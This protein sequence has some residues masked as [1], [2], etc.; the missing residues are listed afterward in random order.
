MAY[1]SQHPL[2]RK[3]LPTN[4]DQSGRWHSIYLSKINNIQTFLGEKLGQPYI[5]MCHLHVSYVC[6]DKSIKKWTQNFSMG[7]EGTC[8]NFSR[9][10]V[11]YCVIDTLYVCLYFSE[12]RLNF[13][14]EMLTFKP[15]W[16]Y[17]RTFQIGRTRNDA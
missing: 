14:G 1:S 13:L 16:L 9:Q 7:N 2:Y 5:F 17:R 8:L 6:F 3:T 4:V 11:Q 12:I 10:K 15:L